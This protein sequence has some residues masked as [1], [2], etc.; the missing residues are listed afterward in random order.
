MLS[1]V[2]STLHTKAGCTSLKQL[3][4]GRTCENTAHCL[5]AAPAHSRLHP[6]KWVFLFWTDAHHFSLDSFQCFQHPR[7]HV[8][9]P[10]CR[11]P[12]VGSSAVS[13]LFS[14]H[15]PGFFSDMHHTAFPTLAPDKETSQLPHPTTLGFLPF[16]PHL[17]SPAGLEV[18]AIITA[19]YTVS[20]SSPQ[21]TK[22][23][24][25]HHLT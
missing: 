4:L 25:T 1:P 14:S 8:S 17:S 3:P 19:P 9:K 16:F 23:F 15:L 5:L 7:A 20:Q 2:T 6:P 10:Q 21:F 12:T 13:R 18:V 24:H 22:Y 11:I